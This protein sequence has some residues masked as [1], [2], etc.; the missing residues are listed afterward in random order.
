MIL[1]DQGLNYLGF[2]AKQI[3]KT[4][5]D[6]SCT[7]VLA[8]LGNLIRAISF[9]CVLEPEIGKC[10]ALKYQVTKVT[11]EFKSFHNSLGSN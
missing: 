6:L 9:A 2:Q 4:L 7:R 10:R 3:G 1:G 8:N 5:N 11:N